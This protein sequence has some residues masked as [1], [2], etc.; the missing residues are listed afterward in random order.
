[1]APVSSS[2]SIDVQT[3]KQSCFRTRKKLA[4]KGTQK[5]CDVMLDTVG[6]E[7]QVVNKIEQ[8][9]SLETDAFVVL[10]PNQDQE[11]T[12][13]LLPINFHGMPKQ[14]MNGEKVKVRVI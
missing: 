1:M 3:A 5:L 4:I 10:T 9:I 7:L 14:L 12:S 13:K 2:V 11:A 8:S 6:P